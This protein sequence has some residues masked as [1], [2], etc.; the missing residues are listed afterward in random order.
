MRPIP[1]TEVI[2]GG[3]EEVCACGTAAAITP[4][5]SI[6]YNTS[7]GEK[8]RIAIGGGEV[9][10]PRFLAVLAELTGIQSGVREDK[11]GWTWPKEGVD[12]SV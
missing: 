11:F 7:E 10:G 1:F 4:I 8:T 3:F 5:R 6:T 2:P 9:A 12:G